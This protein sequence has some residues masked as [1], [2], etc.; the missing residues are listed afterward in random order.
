MTENASVKDYLM[1][2][3]IV[4]IWSITAILGILISIASIELVFYRTLIASAMLGLIFLWKKTSI[5]VSKSEL[6]KIS[7]TRFLIS[8]LWIIM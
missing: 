5:R 6:I 2:H 4:A 7:V 8:I 3:F 1:L